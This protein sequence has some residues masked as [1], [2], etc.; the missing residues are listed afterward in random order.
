MSLS[1][2]Q[3]QR[4]ALAR[5]VYSNAGLVLLDDTFSALDGETEEHGEYLP[6]TLH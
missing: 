1:G 5:A 3:R 6:P 2:G 4:V